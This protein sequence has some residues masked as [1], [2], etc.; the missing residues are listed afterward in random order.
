MMK[1]LNMMYAIFF[2]KKYDLVGHLFQGRYRDVVIDSDAYNLDV[3]CYIHLNPVKAG[4]VD[5]PEDYP[6]SSFRN[7]MGRRK[8]NI[9]CTERV[10]SYFLGKC[11]ESYRKYVEG[12]S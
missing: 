7:Y 10:L 9:V 5:S 12:S 2:N 3:S 4:M 6:W 8:D 11:S 1:Q